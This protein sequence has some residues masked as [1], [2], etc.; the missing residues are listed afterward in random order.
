MTAIQ[1]W[2]YVISVLLSPLL[3]VQATVWIQKRREIRER[4]LALFKTLMKTRAAALAP[5]HVQALNMIDI[6][7]YG[8]DAISREVLR[9][10]KAYLDHLNMNVTATEVWGTKR[11]DLFIELLYSMAKC[12]GYEFDKTDI[13][14]TSYF[15]QGHGD[16]DSELQ[17]IRKGFADVVEGKRHLPVTV[18]P[19]PQGNQTTP[20]ENNEHR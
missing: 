20:R 12:L 10:W 7:F 15:P 4:K 6:E 16:I 9:C 19:A 1:F 18:Y 13:R 8:N 5:D 17:R 2:I 11:E 14:R 3:A